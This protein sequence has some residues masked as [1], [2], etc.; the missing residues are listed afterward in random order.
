MSLQRAPL[1]GAV[2]LAAAGGEQRPG[3]ELVRQLTD[4]GS[5]GCQIYGPRL[6]PLNSRCRMTLRTQK[7]DHKFDNHPYMYYTAR[8]SMA[9]VQ[10][11][12]IR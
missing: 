6:G 1:P 9:L 11:V 10:K 12:Y 5:H 7:R 4:P 8:I 2:V 3:P